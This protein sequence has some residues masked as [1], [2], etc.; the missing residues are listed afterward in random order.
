M[1]ST[2]HN[3]ILLDSGDCGYRLSPD[4]FV[5]ID[6]GGA[7][8]RVAAVD[9]GSG[10]LVETPNFSV[11]LNRTYYSM[12]KG[13]RRELAGPRIEFFSVTMVQISEIRSEGKVK[14]YN[15][16]LYPQEPDIAKRY[17]PDEKDLCLEQRYPRFYEL[18]QVDTAARQFAEWKMAT[19]MVQDDLDEGDVLIKDGSLQTKFPQENRYADALH[20]AAKEKDVVVCGLSKTSTMVTEAG[21]PLLARVE[22]ISRE[23][24]LDRWYIKVAQKASPDGDLTVL[25]A[26]FHPSSEFVFRFEMLR[27]QFDALG[28]EGIGEVLCS[29]SANSDDYSMI[30]YPYAA[31][32]ADRFAQVRT[33]ELEMYK[34]VFASMT[35]QQSG[36]D[37]ERIHKYRKALMA[38][39][40]L[41]EVTG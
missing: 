8:R 22:E 14:S 1:N 35:S 37:W 13:R 9:G 34:N 15:T 28:E 7:L 11:T 36:E 20:R 38:H 5:G 21:E 32:D 17:L 12:F 6:C 27:D 40:R 3:D 10:R 4:K 26:K 30:G 16:V 41:N 19:C 25:V 2:V 29:I 31:V 18:A 33:E 23:S 24:G 39:D